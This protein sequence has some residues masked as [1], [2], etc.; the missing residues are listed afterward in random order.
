MI[1]AA[2]GMLSL[3]PVTAV[4]C[5]DSHRAADLRRRRSTLPARCVQ[6]A[7]RRL[8]A[9]EAHGH[10]AETRTQA[11]PAC[12]PIEGVEAPAVREERKDG[13]ARTVG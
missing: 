7:A 8:R 9:G 13:T 12:H 4:M 1:L 10:D 5:R 6:L 3:L 2:V 11:D